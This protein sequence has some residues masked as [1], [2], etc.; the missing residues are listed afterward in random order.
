MGCEVVV[1][2]DH[3]AV[4]GKGGFVVERK[5]VEV[6]HRC[7]WEGEVVALTHVTVIAVNINNG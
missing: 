4:A 1:R 6:V 3:V 7:C 5:E 2:W